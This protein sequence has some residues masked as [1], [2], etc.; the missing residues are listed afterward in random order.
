MA[1]LNISADRFTTAYNNYLFIPGVSKKVE[2]EYLSWSN[3]NKLLN[4][5][6]PELVVEFE[7]D[8]EGSFAHRLKTGIAEEMRENIP[9]LIK[10]KQEKLETVTDWK[11]KAKLE[12]DIQTLLFDNR[13]WYVLPYLVDRDS[14]LRTPSLFFPVMDN[15]NNAILSPDTRDI[16]DAKARGGV[17]CIA[18]NTG[19]GLRVYTREDIAPKGLINDSPKWKRISSIISSS[20][21]LGKE[22]DTSIVH[23]GK[24]EE[25]LENIAVELYKESE[26]L[27]VKE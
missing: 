2:L 1:Y 10:E 20:N 3:A 25:F 27:R 22:V 21:L 18:L 24:S 13:G 26:S 23:L 6:F 4:Q 11:A 19:L 14:E 17:K 15:K 5:F 12:E 16:N 9:S 7:L 8:D